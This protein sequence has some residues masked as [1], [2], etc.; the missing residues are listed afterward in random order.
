MKLRENKSRA[1]N[2]I[3]NIIFSIINKIIVLFFPFLNRTIIIYILGI[4]YAGLNSLFTSVLQ[5]LNLAELGIGTAIVY[6]MYKPI[7]EKNTELVCA[8][9]KYM[10]KLYLYIGIAVGCVG[11]LLIPCLPILVNGDLPNDL[12]IIVLYTIYLVNAVI[13]Y[14]FFAYRGVIFNA[15]QKMGVERNINSIII[16]LQG[17][18]QL[19]ILFIWKSYYLYLLIMPVFTLFNNIL[20]AFFSKKMYPEY[21]PK[22]ELDKSMKDDIS[23]R[24]K[25]LVISKICNVSRNAFDSIFI[26]SMIG[27]KIVAIYDNYYYIMNAIC[28]LLEVFTIAMTASVGNSIAVETVGKNY[29]DMRKINFMFNWILGFC[30]VCLLVMYQPFMELWMGKERMFPNEMVILLSIY[31]YFLNVGRIRAV[32]HDA[33]GLWWEARYRAVFEAVLNLILNL[34]LTYKLGVLGTILGTLISLIIV[35]YIYGT[36][37]VFKYYFKEISS[38]QYFIDNF[39]FMLTICLISMFL[40]WMCSIFQYGSIMKLILGFLI[41]L[42][43]FNLMYFI[44]Y[45]KSVIF[46]DSFK[47]IGNI[48]KTLHIVD[49]KG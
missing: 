34:I 47:M 40:F 45:R 22:G 4:E 9:L 27:L 17:L 13:G 19:A 28:G 33:A 21:Y 8:L 37:I 43:G 1:E 12:N 46:K 16:L 3:L 42:I 6:C 41:C 29:G 48:V 49:G 25:G 30:T 31:F 5:V 10:R 20:I 11:V 18:A 26:S 24:V 44:I 35:N 36:Q 15:G 14:F 39:G 32:Y 7:A 23:V 2:T 38:I